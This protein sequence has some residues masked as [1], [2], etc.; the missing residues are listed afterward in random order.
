MRVFRGRVNKSPKI[1][2]YDTGLVKG[3]SG[4]IFENLVANS[5]QKHVSGLKDIKGEDK[6]LMYLRDKENRE[7]DFAIID[8]DEIDLLVEA[9]LSDTEISQHL[10]YFSTKNNLK[11]VQVVNNARH[12]LSKSDLIRMVPAENFLKTLFM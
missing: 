12:E 9:K 5:L 6:K 1:Y 11:A 2:F 3:D 7:V 10:R 4:I 8:E